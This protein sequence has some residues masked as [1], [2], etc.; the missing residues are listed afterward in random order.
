MD[1]NSTPKA[2]KVDYKTLEHAGTP[3]RGRTTEEEAN[4]VRNNLDVVNR[5]RIDQGYPPI[6]PQDPKDAARYGFDAQ[7]AEDRPKLS[8]DFKS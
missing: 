8:P 1:C 4:I 7:K 5:R 3:H 6:D 2:E